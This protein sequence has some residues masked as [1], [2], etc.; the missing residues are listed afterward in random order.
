MLKSEDVP[1]P[2]SLCGVGFL[3]GDGTMEDERVISDLEKSKLEKKKKEIEME[4]AQLRKFRMRKKE[5]QHLEE[6]IEVVE[7]FDGDDDN[8]LEGEDELEIAEFVPSGAKHSRSM[9]FGPRTMSFG[10]FRKGR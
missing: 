9:S 5:S 1:F 7:S 2:F 4:D 3:F 10:R 6:G 8:W